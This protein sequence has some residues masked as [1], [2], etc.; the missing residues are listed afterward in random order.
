MYEDIKILKKKFSEI[1]KAGF[2]ESKSSGSGSAGRTLEI[3][4]GLNP[5]R[6]NN[7]DFNSIEIKTKFN[8]SIYPVTLFSKA[9]TGPNIYEN[10]RIREKY[11]YS[12]SNNP[13]LKNFN[14]TINS[15]RKNNIGFRYKFQL[16]VDYN[17]NK[18]FLEIYNLFN[19]LIERKAYWDF[20]Q[21]RIIVTKKLK[22]VAFINV[23]KRYIN[24][25]IHFKYSNLKLYELISFDQ[26]IKLIDSGIITIS[27]KLSTYESGINKG[28]IRDHGTSFNINFNNIDYLFNEI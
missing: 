19:Q 26:F 15:I 18:I 16:L 4:L 14:G 3:L 17:K 27:F 12:I 2:I 23:E 13:I 24:G 20:E 10:Q 22:H 5:G 6:S 8:N 25:E 11:G 28:K 7:P 21:I 1:S 9:L